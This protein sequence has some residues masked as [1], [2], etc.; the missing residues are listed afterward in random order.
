M[1]MNPLPPQA[2]T[3]ETMLKAYAW[4]MNQPPSIKELA[5]TPDILVS[6][7]LKAQRDGLDSLD[8]PSIQNF[9]EE[10]KSLAG[11]MSTLSSS[12]QA[13]TPSGSSPAALSPG[14]PSA[15][16]SVASGIS[17]ETPSTPVQDLQSQ[18]RPTPPSATPSM[19]HGALGSPKFSLEGLDERSLSMIREVKRGLNLSNDMD[20]LR[21]L[22]QLGFQALRDKIPRD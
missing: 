10:L 15:I 22:V 2:Y 14:A 18:A 6:L 16:P 3:K 21:A 11:M 7:Y 19:N 9:R 12:Q 5:T 13:T 1:S 8:R 20:S 4:V 17:A